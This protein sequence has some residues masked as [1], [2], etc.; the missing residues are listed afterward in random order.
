M[1]DTIVVITGASGGIG[2]AVAELATGQGMSAVLA[3]RRKEAL[4]AVAAKCGGRALPVVAD[5]TVRANVR[6]IVEETLAHFGRIDVW[7]NN[8]GVGITR[9]PS[10]LTDQDIDT[11]IQANVK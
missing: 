1:S 8:A 3:A 6:R 10:Q 9:P 4:E 2:A 7:I 11:M 5:V